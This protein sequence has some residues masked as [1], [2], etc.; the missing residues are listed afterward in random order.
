[1]N[2]AADLDSSANPM[3]Y[4]NYDIPRMLGN[5]AAAP[6]APAAD[7]GGNNFQLYD[8]PRSL[9]ATAISMP[10]DPRFGNYDYPQNGPSATSQVG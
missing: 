1:M 3:A 4:A 8:T 10:N 5:G 2:N 7:G 6:V 9:A